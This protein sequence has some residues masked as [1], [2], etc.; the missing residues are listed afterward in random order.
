MLAL[1]E[2]QDVKCLLWQ[3]PQ[4]LGSQRQLCAVTA[5]C[6]AV[7]RLS[8]HEVASHRQLEVEIDALQRKVVLGIQQTRMES[9]EPLERF[10]R[11]R[12]RV[13][14]A[15][16]QQHGL[17]SERHCQRILRWRDHL[18]RP[19]NGHSWAAIL[20]HHRGLDWLMEQ[21]SLHQGGIFAGRTGTRVAAGF[22][23]TRWHDGVR[24]ADGSLWRQR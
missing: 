19:R 20:L 14:A 17:W 24:Y 15:F 11:R 23:A 13:A 8:E 9:G 3:L 4:E 6:S 16:C 21:R 5:C 2:E 10:L 22:V 18:E 1:Y 7:L 12:R